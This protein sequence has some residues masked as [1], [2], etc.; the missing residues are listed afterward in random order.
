MPA[1][2][3]DTPENLASSGTGR[4]SQLTETLIAEVSNPDILNT[5]SLILSAADITHRILLTPDRMQI[6]VAES[7]RERA[8]RELAEYA[9]EN[10]ITPVSQ[11]NEPSFTPTFR[12]MA[13]LVIGVLVLLY[14]VSGDWQPDASWFDK[15]AGDSRA[16]LENFQ[17][18]RLITSLTLHADVVHVL[19]NGILGVFLLHFFFHL[20]GNGIGLTL[21]LLTSASANLLNV[22]VHGPGHLFV[23]FSTATFSVIGM[24]CTMSFI[25]RTSR[26]RLHFFMPIMAGLALLAILGSSGERTD[27][28]AHLFGLLCGLVCGNVMRL[29]H[30]DSLRQSM[31]LQFLLALAMAGLV[32]GC[33]LAA[34]Y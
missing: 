5:S 32:L 15:G 13:P 31:I 7:D 8:L 14:G 19:S 10:E 30:F 12:A 33:W 22:L 2:E 27:L 16:I 11:R 34:L 26:F 21:L 20:T 4:S 29:P 1:N 24:L 3:P 25:G 9:L 23:G 18:Y 28:G 17:F 6:F